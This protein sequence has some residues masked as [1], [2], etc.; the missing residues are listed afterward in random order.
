MDLLKVCNKIKNQNKITK[1]DMQIQ[2]SL[3]VCSNMK[4]NSINEFN[5]LKYI[6]K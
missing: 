3:F 4:K 6:K 1:I 5:L 2:Q